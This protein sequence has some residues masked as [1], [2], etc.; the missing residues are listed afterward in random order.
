MNKII[1]KN[2]EDTEKFAREIAKSIPLGTVVELIGDLGAGKTTFAKG[3]AKGLGVK[4]VVTSPTFTLLN[5][6][7][8]DGVVLNHFDLYRIDDEEELELMGVKEMFY[9]TDSINL[10]EW[11]QIARN[12]LPQKKYVIEI[13][14]IDDKTREIILE[15]K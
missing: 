8:G 7:Q 12:L 13:N 6:Y 1:S 11:P 2:A 15:K 9:D 10:I 5:T 14:K 3:F 4:G